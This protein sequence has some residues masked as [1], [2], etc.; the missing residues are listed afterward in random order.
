MYNSFQIFYIKRL[1]L[2]E[3]FTENRHFLIH[4]VKYTTMLSEL[5]K[6]CFLRQELQGYV[7]LQY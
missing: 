4:R 3:W 2:V 1:T 7:S 6:L 5:L